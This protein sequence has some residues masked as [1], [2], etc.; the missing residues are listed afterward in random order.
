MHPAIIFPEMLIM[1]ERTKLESE[2]TMKLR[3]LHRIK[4]LLAAADE[5]DIHED[6][7]IVAEVIAKLLRRLGRKVRVYIYKAFSLRWFIA[8]ARALIKL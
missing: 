2:V 5:V 7:P 4:K 6:N 1:K 3:F 8:A